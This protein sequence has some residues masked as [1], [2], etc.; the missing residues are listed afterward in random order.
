MTDLQARVQFLSSLD[1]GLAYMSET[2]T[3]L[4]PE[5]LDVILDIL[6]TLETDPAKVVSLVALPNA[7]RRIARF[8]TLGISAATEALPDPE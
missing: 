8:A 2:L 4:E 7:T 1:Q 5:E 3:K 6:A